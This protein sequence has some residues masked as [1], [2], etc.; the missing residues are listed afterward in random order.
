MESNQL[1]DAFT[2]ML[3]TQHAVNIQLTGNKHY[4]YDPAIVY[5]RAIAEE[6]G[7]L[8][9]HL[10]YKWW[11]KTFAEM[12]RARMEVIDLLHFELANSLTER[13]RALSQTDYGGKFD[14]YDARVAQATQSLA[15]LFALSASGWVHR[16]TCESGAAAMNTLDLYR[17]ET[18]NIQSLEP[19]LTRMSSL[20]AVAYNVGL[21]VEQMILWYVGKATLNIFRNEHGYTTG[22]YIKNWKYD[23][24]AY[25]NMG[26]PADCAW[27]E[28]NDALEWIIS[29]ARLTTFAETR[30]RMYATL[31]ALYSVQQALN[32]KEVRQ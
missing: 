3:Q 15:S 21:T 20:F 32:V 16:E 4:V 9:A 17:A 12:G 26:I 24:T 27:A 13:I 10:G 18:C 5:D 8:Y 6:I 1:L 28:D 7:E 14:D 30:G 2:N 22:T 31:E 19:A 23:A 29:Q 25:A 11:K